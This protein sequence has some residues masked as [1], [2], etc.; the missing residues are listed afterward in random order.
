MSCVKNLLSLLL[1]S[2]LMMLPATSWADSVEGRLTGLKCA[3]KGKLCPSDKDDPHVMMER[4]F[5]VMREDGRYFFVTNMDWHTKLGFILQMVRVEGQLSENQSVIAADEFW[6]KRGGEYRL[7]W[8]LE[9]ARKKARAQ[10]K[11]E[12]QLWLNSPNEN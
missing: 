7:E 3:T 5:V 1:V 12:Q 9:R 2:P 11:R 6:V 4:D 10:R 8:S